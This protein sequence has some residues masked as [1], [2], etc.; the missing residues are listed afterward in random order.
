MDSA[1]YREGYLMKNFI[2]TIFSL[3]NN[4]LVKNNAVILL[5]SLIGGFGNYLY[6]LAMTRML[7]PR[8]YA[9][10]AAL[11]SLFS[12]ISIP[13]SVAQIS[14]SRFSAEM[15]AAGEWEKLSFF[16]K[17]TAKYFLKLGLAG[18]AAF[19]IFT[20]FI[21]SFLNL[22]DIYPLI[23]LSF[24]IILLFVGMV[25]TGAL[26][27]MQKFAAY[28]VSGI[29]STSA[30]LLLAVFL[31]FLG[32]KISGA[33]LGAVLGSLIAIAYI[34][35]SLKLSKT[36]KSFFIDKSKIINYS[37][38]VLLATFCLTVLG[39]IDI[40][41]VKHFWEAAEA[42]NYS[43]LSLTGK[44]VFFLTSAAALV[45][46]PIVIDRQSRREKHSHILKYSSFL[47]LG[48]GFGIT[49]IYF[50]VP[51]IVIRL[52]FG[53]AYLSIAPYL[54]YFG[55]IMTFFS[56]INL[57]ATYYLSLNNNKFVAALFLGTIAEILLISLFHQNIGQIIVDM[58]AMTVLILIALMAP[59][60]KRNLLNVKTNHY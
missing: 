18:F 17:Q 24:T 53:A 1:K 57:L 9:E 38:T 4:N 12:I 33:V 22:Y 34:F 48:V 5:G 51:G 37:K 43:V 29:I 41:L 16:I 58:A 3:I 23:I 8:E 20:P 31:V 46:F 25:G 14:I 44:I 13:A 49:A 27:G 45:M 2:R 15:A 30:K 32:L 52:L 6:N 40:I 50:F 36:E 42:A 39:N 28:S 7:E 10:I 47:V 19:L 35:Y 55:L 21:K 59:Q 60:I 54:G 56:L 26:Q 11:F